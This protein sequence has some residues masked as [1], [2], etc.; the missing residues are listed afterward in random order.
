MFL[1]TSDATSTKSQIDKLQMKVWGMAYEGWSFHFSGRNRCRKEET[2]KEELG[3]VTGWRS[4]IHFSVLPGRAVH[5]SRDIR[6][7]THAIARG[8]RGGWR[9]PRTLTCSSRPTLLE[10]TDGLL[11]VQLLC[12]LNTHVIQME[13][14]EL[15]LKIPWRSL[16]R[17]RGGA[18]HS[19]WSGHATYCNWTT[20]RLRRL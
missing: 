4:I 15:A 2:V 1:C 18:G 5:L 13:S 12:I 16:T 14:T 20:T 19:P 10:R 6:A 9:L 11:I 8:S 7:K 3:Y 17:G